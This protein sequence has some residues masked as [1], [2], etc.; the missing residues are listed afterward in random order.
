MDKNK[1]VFEKMNYILMLVG[2]AI[3]LLGFYFMSADKEPYGWG[4]LGKTVGPVTVLLGFIVEF[5]AIFY[6]SK[7]KE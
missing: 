3:I 1:L 7:R 2:I 5:F 6:K 4:T